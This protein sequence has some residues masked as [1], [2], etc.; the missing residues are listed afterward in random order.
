MGEKKDLLKKAMEALEW[1]RLLKAL[2]SYS[3]SELGAHACENL[4]L[5]ETSEAVQRLL[6]ETA[7]MTDLMREGGAVPS[8]QMEDIRPAMERA[9]KGAVINA[10]EL[11]QVSSLLETTRVIKTFF[12]NMRLNCP[13]LWERASL[14][15]ELSALK[16]DIDCAIDE[17]GSLREDASDELRRLSRRVRDKRAHIV[18]ELE[19]FMRSEEVLP[20]LQDI[21]YTQ[22]GS[23]Y[24]L[25]VKAEFRNKIEGIVHDSSNSGQTLFIEPRKFTQLNNELKMAEMELEQEITRILSEL[26]R[27][28]GA[29]AD[30]IFSNI[31]IL[32][33]IDTIYAKARLAID[34]NATLPPLAND[35]KISLKSARHPLLV[36]EQLKNPALLV[37]PNDIELP[38]QISAMVIS[39]PNTGGKTVTLKL[40][41]LFALMVRAGMLIP[42]KSGSVMSFF[43]EVYADI[44][45]EQE[46]EMHLSSFSGHITNIIGIMDCAQRGALVLLDELVTSTDPAE[47]AALGEAIL[48]AL[49]QKGAKTVVTTHYSQLKAFAQADS[50][51][52]NAS[53]EFDPQTLSPTYRLI[54][55][56]PGRSS[57]LEIASRLG[58]PA[59]LI[60]RARQRLNSADR[61]LEE[62]IGS[63]ENQRRE[64]LQT[65]QKLEEE[66]TGA[67]K[68]RLEQEKILVEVRKREKEFKSTL[69]RKINAEVESARAKVEEVLDFL[70]KEQKRERAI[71]ARRRLAEIEAR[72][73]LDSLGESIKVD[74]STLTAGKNV[75]ITTIGSAG[76]LLED[77]VQAG[78]TKRKLR[79]RVGATEIKVPIEALLPDSSVKVE[80]RATEISQTK[81]IVAIEPKSSAQRLDL[82][83]F[84]VEDALIEVRKF[85]DNALLAQLKEVEIIHGHGTGALKKAIREHLTSSPYVKSWRPA[86]IR[87]G[88]DGVTVIELNL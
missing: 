39:G 30:A 28:V 82:R 87:F 55:G 15:E 31:E 2:A 34:L 48:D 33:D 38:S 50:R 17:S 56:T 45:D 1:H 26:S 8:C 44:G 88:G 41:G 81:T 66:R 73:T 46:I 80:K 62:L 32:T 47:G 11:K 18:G 24:V 27:K 5:A 85:L 75:I 4:P 36:I 69:K 74:P 19:E 59:E 29:N 3:A 65:L 52:I 84:R 79:V 23:R 86:D 67:E 53:V 58:M 57:A 25:P 83:G 70:A 51:F 9:R 22:R 68:A 37:V 42:A 64:L 16:R 63:L 49:A 10:G 35:G 6:N 40:L 77:A 21:Y 76:I 12:K 60:E 71:E 13:L 78:K 72:Y 14:L 20:Y 54:I 61:K 43:P 7:E